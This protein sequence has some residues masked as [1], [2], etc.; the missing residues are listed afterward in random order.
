VARG[1][2]HRLPRPSVNALTSIARERRDHGAQSEG[3]GGRRYAVLCATT[4]KPSL[5]ITSWQE[6]A[7]LFNTDGETD[8]TVEG[9]AGC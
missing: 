1:N 8:G 2:A 5:E 4:R 6:R 9:A 3:S 7:L